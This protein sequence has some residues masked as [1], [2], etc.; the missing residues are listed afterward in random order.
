M[1]KVY[2][3]VI[4]LVLSTTIM[5]AQKAD[6]TKRNP[7]WTIEAGFNLPELYNYGFEVNI[8]YYP[9]KR[10]WI[11]IGPSMQAMYFFT[12]N[13]DWFPTN[14]KTTALISEVYLNLIGNVEFT[15]SKK[16]SF[17]IGMAPYLGYEMINNKGTVKND[18]IQLD[19]K[20]NYT[21]HIFDF[22]MR[23][24]LGGYIG[25]KQKNGLQVQFQSSLRGLTDKDPRTKAVNIGLP[26][27]K[28]F[29]GVTYIYKI[30]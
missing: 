10:S 22:G 18:A 25:K 4:M 1:K 27:F 14:N 24:K 26:N 30:K 3:F 28:T 23:Y 6:S 9:F 12:P 15:P 2:L 13:K 19:L 20:Y 7:T 17:F 16:K 5:Q 11:R 8:G 29:V 21:V